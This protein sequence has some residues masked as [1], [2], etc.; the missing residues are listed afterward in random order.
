MTNPG[1]LII[2]GLMI[3]LGAAALLRGHDS[4][5]HGL[6]RGTEQLVKLLPRMFFALVAASFLAILMPTEFIGKFLGAEAGIM[7]IVTGSLAGMIVPAGPAISF[8]IAAVLANEGASTPALVSFITSWGVFAMHR[9]FIF[10]MPLL[11]LS[12][13]RLRILS[14]LILP[15]IAGGLTLGAMSLIPAS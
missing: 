15:P 1:F 13:T 4:F 7:A 14:G 11:G 9:V 6:V 2:L 12:F 10:E 5:R 8:S 3:I